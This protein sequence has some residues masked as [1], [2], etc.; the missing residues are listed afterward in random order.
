[1]R[2]GGR[3]VKLIGDSVMFVADDS[4]AATEIALVLV[5]TFTDHDVVPPVRAGVATGNVVAREGD[6]SGEIVNLAARAVASGR[7]S[8]LLVDDDTARALE[9]HPRYSRRAAGAF[10][11]K[12][13][14]RA[15]TLTRVRRTKDPLAGREG[16]TR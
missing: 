9:G 13:F 4:V 15:I 11:L 16:P 2:H 5:D 1:M 7:P 14:D 12:G 8:S 10:A 3:V 6:Y